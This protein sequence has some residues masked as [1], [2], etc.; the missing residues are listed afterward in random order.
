MANLRVP[1]LAIVQKR[2]ATVAFIKSGETLAILD[3]SHRAFGPLFALST[4]LLFLGVGCDGCM[5]TSGDD[6]GVPSSGGDGEVIRDGES[7]AYTFSAEQSRFLITVFNKPAQVGCGLFHSHVVNAESMLLDFSLNEDDVGSSTLNATI[8]AAGLDPD[9]PDL[10]DEILGDEPLSQNDRDTI[11][12][13]LIDQVKGAEHPRLTFDASNFTSLTDG[14]SGTLDVAVAI[15][16]G[17]QTIQMDY[18]FSVDADGKIEIH[19]TGTLPGAPHDIPSGFASDCVEADMN[20]LLDLVLEPGTRDQPGVLP[21]AGI[22]VYEPTLFPFEDGCDADKISFNE[23]RDVLVRKCASCHMDPIRLGATIPLVEYDDF[24][25][26]SL[27]NQGRPMYETIADFI[28]PQGDHS[29]MPPVNDAAPIT[30]AEKQL[31]LDWIAEG[32]ADCLDAATPTVFV[33]I[34]SVACGPVAY[35]DISSIVASNCVFCHDSNQTA[36]PLLETFGDGLVQ[37]LHPFYGPITVWEAALYRMEDVTM[38][39]YANAAPVAVND[40]ALFRTWVEDG[41]PEVHCD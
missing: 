37:N 10:R 39:P 38:P 22:E 19:G 7:V 29:V 15:G 3:F 20:L 9:D 33:P 36:L 5:R 8:A 12:T 16:G 17:N 14:A 25:T 23:V 21:D 18:D 35:Q 28:D 30:D 24:R 26:D 1:L 2:D 4:T 13:S 27:R 11:K 34:A 31:A 32:A 41:Y 6:A 40:I